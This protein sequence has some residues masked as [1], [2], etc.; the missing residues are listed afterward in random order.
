MLGWLWSRS[1]SSGFEPVAAIDHLDPNHLLIRVE[2]H[3]DGVT[4]RKAGVP[5]DVTDQLGREQL[6]GEQQIRVPGDCGDARDGATGLARRMNRQMQRLDQSR[7][8]GVPFWRRRPSI[9]TQP[10]NT[11]APYPDDWGET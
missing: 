9:G 6:D 11:R 2:D 1:W 7:S 10:V 3:R 5:F 8:V 4:G